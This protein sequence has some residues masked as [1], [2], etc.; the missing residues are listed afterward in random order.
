MTLALTQ[1]VVADGRDSIASGSS[2]NAP[3]VKET[4]VVLDD[5]NAKAWNY[6][7]AN[8]DSDTIDQLLVKFDG[9]A[10]AIVQ[11][12]ADSAPSNE[13]EPRGPGG[14][15]DCATAIAVVIGASNLGTNIGF[16]DDTTPPACGVSTPNQ[17]VWYSVVGNG[18][19]LTA[20]TC[21]AGTTFDTL[22]EV[23]CDNCTTPVCVGGNDT[24]TSALPDFDCTGD[25]SRFSWCSA[26]GT[27]YYIRVSGWSASTGNFDFRVTDNGTSCATPPSCVPPTGRCCYNDAG[28]GTCAITT[29]AAC[30]LLSGVWTT[31]ITDCVASP[32][33]TGRCCYNDGGNVGCVIVMQ[34]VCTSLAGT[35]T[36]GITDCVA[37]PCPVGRCCYND[38]ASCVNTL[39]SICT[40]LAGSFSSTL[41]CATACPVAP[42]NNAC[43]NAITITNGTTPFNLA[44]A[45]TDGPNEPSC[46]FPSGGTNQN[47]NQDI[48]YHYTATCT[49]N[50][51]V[52]TCGASTTD[53][54]IAI[55]LGDSCPPASTP[56]QCNDDHAN[57]TE[58][59]MGTPCPA[60]LE[61]SLQIPVT[62]GQIYTIR[63]GAF[64]TS[65]TISGADQLNVDC[66]APGACCLPDTSCQDVASLAACTTLG[67]VFGGNGSACAT[68]N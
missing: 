6:L 53:T 66:V 17:G 19:N 32:C 40:T 50:L 24:G 36:S 56:I 29:Q 63:V 39:A 18:N 16:L 14:N 65:G 37:S 2:V 35:W 11:Y 1:H 44:N 12:L 26:N 68:T 64:S 49:G 38:G 54:R 58:N 30:A 3:Q 25:R 34:P 60:G 62:Q 42:A 57:A 59:D 45:T 15:D 10:M 22:V 46:A 67:G 28:V 52:N 55:Y 43:A 27:T 23:F 31:G 20:S 41:T 48:W 9:D 21:Y 47:M 51:F 4:P 61:A 5:Q 7:V 8:F 13:G 33:P